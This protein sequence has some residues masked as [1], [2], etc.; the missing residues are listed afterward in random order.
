MLTSDIDESAAALHH[1]L[2][3][4]DAHLKFNIALASDFTIPSGELLRLLNRHRLQDSLVVA[5]D[6]FAALANL[7]TGDLS[8]AYISL[9]AALEL[10]HF[11]SNATH[12]CKTI[13]KEKDVIAIIRQLAERFYNFSFLA[14]LQLQD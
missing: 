2:A 10:A 4:L 11:A 8:S 7:R 13:R 12:R 14:R 5:A 1:L 6:I 9:R 3:T